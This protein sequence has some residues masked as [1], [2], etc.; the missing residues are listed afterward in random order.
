MSYALTHPHFPHEST[1]NQFFTESQFESY[2]ALGFEVA[3]KA[4]G[5]AE[6][7]RRVNTAPVDRWE[8]KS[9][10][11]LDQ[12]VECLEA[13]LRRASSRT[14]VAE[15]DRQNERTQDQQEQADLR[16]LLGRR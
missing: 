7:E 8:D 9:T 10:M 6:R 4:L 14:P 3:T 1:T 2:R 11:R 13:G 5:Y 12:I 16:S 15:I